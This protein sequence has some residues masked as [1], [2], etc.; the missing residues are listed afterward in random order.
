MEKYRQRNAG[1]WSSDASFGNNGVFLIPASLVVKRPALT[2]VASDGLGWEHVSVSSA[3]RCPTWQEMCFV[4]NL[5][6]DDEDC[7][8]QLHPPKSKW[9]NNHPYCLH[10]WRP[11]NKDIPM[12]LEI[13]VGYKDL[14]QNSR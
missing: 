9:I 12:P 6:W 7:V 8:M 10:L 5:F 1:A 4:K 13:M 11:V 14:N 3:T 2:I